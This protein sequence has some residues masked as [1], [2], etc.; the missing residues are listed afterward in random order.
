MSLSQLPISA[1]VITLNEAHNIVACLESL[2]FLPEVI[3]VDS[4]SSDATVSLCQQ[5]ANVRFFH[6]PW[7]GYGAQKNY[8]ASLATQPWILNVDADERV[9]TPLREQLA[10]LDYSG[11]NIDVYSVR[12]ENYFCCKRVRYSGWYPDAQKRLYFRASAAFNAREVHESVE[13]VFPAYPLKSGLI[14]FTY[15][16]LSD[17]LQRMDRYSTLAA[18][19]MRLEG[20]TVRWSDVYLRPFFTFLKMFFFKKGFLDGRMGLTLATLYAMY[21]YAKYLKGSSHFPDE[22]S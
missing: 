6:N 10:I 14:H 2:S 1:T 21:T 17:Y 12:R 5:F 9:S 7:P 4:G 18:R 3:V 8:A 16:S 13:G 11:T 20:R 19:Q 22:L 15:R